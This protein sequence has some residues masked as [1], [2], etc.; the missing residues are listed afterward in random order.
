MSTHLRRGETELPPA[1]LTDLIDYFHAGS[2]PREKWRV[3]AEFE[4][5]ALDRTTGRQL[6]FD[7]PHGIE[8]ILHALVNKTLQPGNQR[9]EIGISRVEFALE[10][11]IPRGWSALGAPQLDVMS[12]PDYPERLGLNAN[13]GSV[14]LDP[15]DAS[16]LCGPSGR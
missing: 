7:G 2:K 14:W 15:A 12:I 8:S 1:S 5:F 3:G 16:I 4:K 13:A 6:T 11:A 9:R 10:A